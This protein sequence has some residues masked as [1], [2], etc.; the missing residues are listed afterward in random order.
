[1]Y[2]VV[3]ERLDPVFSHT[4]NKDQTYLVDLLHISTLENQKAGG[5]KSFTNRLH[6]RKTLSQ[7][8]YAQKLQSRTT[9]MAIEAKLPAY[10]GTRGV[11]NVRWWE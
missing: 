9:L 11:K 8:K 1:M 6:G 5:L 10:L 4:I 7:S 3:W 2:T